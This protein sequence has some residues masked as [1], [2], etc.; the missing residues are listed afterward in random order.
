VILSRV[1]SNLRQYITF[2]HHLFNTLRSL[3]QE[4]T[5]VEYIVSTL[6]NS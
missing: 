1:V 4:A 5:S 2:K 3:T 6:N